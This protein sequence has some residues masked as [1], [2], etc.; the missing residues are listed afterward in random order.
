VTLVERATPLAPPAGLRLVTVGGVVSGAAAVVKLQLSSAASGLPAVSLTPAYDVEQRRC[1]D[2]KCERQEL[3]LPFVEPDDREPAFQECAE[4][5]CVDRDEQ[6][7]RTLSVL[8]V[9]AVQASSRQRVDV[10]NAGTASTR[11]VAARTPA[12]ATSS[13][14]PCSAGARRR[15][16]RGNVGIGN[17]Q[18]NEPRQ[19][20][21]REHADRRGWSAA[22]GDPAL[23]GHPHTMQP[24]TPY[25]RS[26]GAG[27]TL[28]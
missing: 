14:A 2:R 27:A 12:I 7:L 21:Q 5:W 15:S 6:E 26:S 13:H 23:R 16:L 4:A 22:T 11:V 8:I 25:D 28:A 19:K 17:I 3:R 24:R 10:P 1:G 9:S 20:P 18:R